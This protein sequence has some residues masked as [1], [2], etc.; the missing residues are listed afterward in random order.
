MLRTIH[1]TRL[2]G[3]CSVPA[4]CRQHARAARAWDKEAEGAAALKEEVAKLRQWKDEK[5][6][7][8]KHFMEQVTHLL[9]LPF[10]TNQVV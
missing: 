7:E 9:G 4:S 8:M 3:F 2:G 6:A 5:A 1:Y 10:S